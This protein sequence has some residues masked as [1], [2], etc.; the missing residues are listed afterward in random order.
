MKS[1]VYQRYGPPDVIQ[2]ENVETHVDGVHIDADM[3]TANRKR[4]E[5]HSEKETYD[6]RS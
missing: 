4:V 1:A 2:I 6:S 5:K 3:T